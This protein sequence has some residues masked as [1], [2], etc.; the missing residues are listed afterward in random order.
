MSLRGAADTTRP[1]WPL[2]VVLAAM[3]GLFS[4]A[5]AVNSVLADDPAIY[6]TRVDPIIEGAWPY[7]DAV[8]EHFPLSLPFMVIPRWLAPGSNTLAYTAL[9]GALMVAC[10]IGTGLVLRRMAQGADTL[11]GLDAKWAW[12]ALPLVPLVA[13]RIDPV[14]TFLAAL[15][16]HLAW[17]GRYRHALVASIAAIA[18]KGWPVVLAAS[19]WFAGR[20]RRALVLV[21]STVA[22]A[23]ALLA[24][25]GFQQGREFSG[26]QLETIAGSLL[27]WVRSLRGSDPGLF[28]AAGSTYVSAPA[29]VLVVGPVIAAWLLW[30][31]RRA[32][33]EPLSIRPALLLT[34]LAAL[35]L[36]IASPLLSAQFLIW[37]TPWMAAAERPT[38]NVFALCAAVTTGLLAFWSLGA[39]AWHT[40]LLARNAGLIGCGLLLVRDLAP[41]PAE[42][43]PDRP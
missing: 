43:V 17:R 42:P 19:E 3:L 9:F 20:R 13:F 21:G 1:V 41:E 23:A 34:G 32:W 38:R 29:W 27:T 26:I 8:Y 39:L 24:T 31:S 4:E 16:F 12:L 33:R 10:L 36:L 37:L 6:A 14:S 7:V 11:N 2:W 40:A 22:F 30:R 25:P 28:V 15:A 5:L 35:A 18:A